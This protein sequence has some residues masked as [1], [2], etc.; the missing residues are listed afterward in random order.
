VTTRQTAPALLLSLLL[1]IA[2][3]AQAA[4]KPAAE[5]APEPAPAAAPAEKPAPPPPPAAALAGITFE[6]GG[7]LVLNGWADFGALNASDLPRF[8]LRARG[9]QATGAAVR[10]SRLRLGIGLPSDAGLLG[11]A[12]FKAFLEGDFVGG[13]VSGDESA[14][15]PRLRHAWVSATWKALGNLSVLAGQTTDV[16][17]GTVA[18]LSISHLATPR[19]A[20]AGYVYRRAPQVRVQGEVG[21]ELALAYQLG[22]L[23]AADKT[24]QTASATGVGYRSFAPDVE[25]R[26]AV[27]YRGALP[28]KAELGLGAR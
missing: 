21:K 27:L 4:D 11:G 26:A 18:A 8:A 19:F 17:H 12:T 24:T 25:G 2:A 3:A 23:S 1:P 22:L 9:E 7:W 15:L 28:A 14:P 16:F 13:Y 10:Q 5:P 20:G 6:P